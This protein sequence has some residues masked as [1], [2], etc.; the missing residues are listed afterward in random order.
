MKIFGKW[1]DLA[2][3]KFPVFLP[4]AYLSILFGL[5]EAGPM[6]ALA[7]MIILAEPHFG[8]TWTI[9]FDR[10]LREYANSRKTA[11]VW[12]SVFLVLV[13]VF[14]FVFFTARFLPD[15][16]CPEYLSCHQ[17]ERGCLQ[18]VFTGR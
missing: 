14:L 3:I 10:R 4:I 13:S 1:A 16:F 2:L 5:P 9:F 7:T 15:V 11:F 12:A 8:A 6:L 18:A 17:A